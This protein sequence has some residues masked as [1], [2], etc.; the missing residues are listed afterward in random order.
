MCAGWVACH[1]QGGL[2]AL[3]LWGLSASANDIDA[4]LDYETDVEVFRS[5]TEAAEHGLA[6]VRFPDARAQRAITGLVR[7]KALRGDRRRS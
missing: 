5:G 3:R 2:L 6:G 1:D 4:V 7:K